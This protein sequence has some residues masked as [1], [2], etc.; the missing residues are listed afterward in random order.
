M[1][2]EEL[3]NLINLTLKDGVLS[4]KER[5]VLFKRAEKEGVDLDEFEIY[6]NAREFDEQ[7]AAKKSPHSSNTKTD[8]MELSELQDLLMAEDLKIDAK[9]GQGSFNA[10]KM[11]FTSNFVKVYERKFSIICNASIPTTREELLGMIAF[12]KPKADKNG[13]KKGW[14]GNGQD[15]NTTEDLSFAYWTLFESCIGIAKANFQGDP[16]FQQYFD[17]YEKESQKKK[18]GLFSKLFG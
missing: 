15:D 12:A 10:F 9:S 18:S 11:A 17:F 1:Y 7:E 6:L 14:K 8:S 5:T 2:S 3:E 4:D 13:S 16:A